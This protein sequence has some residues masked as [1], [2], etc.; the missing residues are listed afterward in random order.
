MADWVTEPCRSCA[1]PVIWAVTTR[2]K[3]MPVDAVTDADG[4]LV[5]EAR[6][7]GPPLARVLPVAKRFGRRDLRMS[8]FVACPQADQ[9]RAKRGHS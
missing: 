3:A 8:H 1:A 6:V 5:L 7:D 9:W 4:N 2:G